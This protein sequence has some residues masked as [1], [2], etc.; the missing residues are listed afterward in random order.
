[1]MQS[2]KRKKKLL[3]PLKIMKNRFYFTIVT[4]VRKLSFNHTLY[5]IIRMH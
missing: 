1:M 4:K 2:L 3:L 5:A